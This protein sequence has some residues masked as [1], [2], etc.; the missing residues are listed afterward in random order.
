[1]LNVL[2]VELT[3]LPFHTSISSSDRA[4]E[5][6]SDDGGY[7]ALIHEPGK[8]TIELNVSEFISKR[9]VGKHL[10]A[11]CIHCKTFAEQKLVLRLGGS[12]CVCP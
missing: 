6:D 8:S 2:S 7:A 3:T 9:M 1:M 4:R 12:V 10:Y 11:G 5:G